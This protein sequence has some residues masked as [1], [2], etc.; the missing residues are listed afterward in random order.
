MAQLGRPP[1]YSKGLRI[2]MVELYQAGHTV[3]EIS[4][5]LGPS[6]GTVHRVLRLNGAEFRRPGSRDPR[7]R[8]KDG[9]YKTP[10]GET[11]PQ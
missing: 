3:R 9:T 2:R 10:T 7:P 4:K 6:Y 1:V 11:P 8:N 5:M